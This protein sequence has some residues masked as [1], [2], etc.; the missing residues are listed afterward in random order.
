[1]VG[2]VEKHEAL[3]VLDLFRGR[4]KYIPVIFSVGRGQ[5][6]VGLPVARVIVTCGK[7]ASAVPRPAGQK[8][9]T[10]L[11]LIAWS[12]ALLAS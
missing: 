5:V 7:C 10:N 11:P 4:A 12:W 2:T 3:D 1:M 6:P 8:F 9:Q